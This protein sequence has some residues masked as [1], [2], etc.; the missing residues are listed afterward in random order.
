LEIKTKNYLSAKLK[1]NTILKLSKSQKTESIVQG[2]R[3]GGL[4]GML[5]CYVLIL[6]GMFDM[7][8]M[9]KVIGWFLFSSAFFALVGGLI[10]FIMSHS[11]KSP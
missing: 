5:G 6:V 1:E 9:L 11:E 7:S 4:L 2:A 10:G 3:I 8:N